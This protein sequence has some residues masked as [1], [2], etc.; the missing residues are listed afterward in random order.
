M[1]H[2]ISLPRHRYVW[3]MSHYVRS[4]DDGSSQYELIPAVWWGVSVQPNRVLGCHV[5]LENGAMVVDLPLHAM[6]WHT[7]KEPTDRL[8]PLAVKYYTWD[9]YGWDAE[10]VESSYLDEMRVQLLDDQHKLTGEFGELWFAIDHMKDGFGMEPAQH[11][12][13]WVVANSCGRFSWVP[14][15]QLLLYDKSFTEVDGVPKIK[16]QEQAWSAE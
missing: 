13:L 4:S 5:V 14:Q 9:C 2:N 1:P 6:R 7:E 3:V 16:R 15:D 10:I 12:H 11:K 8:L